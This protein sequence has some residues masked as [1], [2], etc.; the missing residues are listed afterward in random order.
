MRSAQSARSYEGTEHAANPTAVRRSWPRWSSMAIRS[1]DPPT[2]AVTAG[3]S[4]QVPS[5]S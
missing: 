4:G 5:R 1:P 3:S 2:A